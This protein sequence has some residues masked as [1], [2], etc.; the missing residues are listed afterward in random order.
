MIF[1]TNEHYRLTLENIQSSNGLVAHRLEN[2]V[3]SAISTG[4]TEQNNDDEQEIDLEEETEEG[5]ADEDDV[6]SIKIK[7]LTFSAYVAFNRI[8]KLS[9]SQLLV[10]SISE[11]RTRLTEVALQ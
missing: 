5:D 11:A 1:F 10:H 3:Q 4:S 2:E 6:S 9:W 7:A 8:L